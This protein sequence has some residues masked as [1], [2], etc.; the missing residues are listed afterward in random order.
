MNQIP[1]RKEPRRPFTKIAVGVFVIIAVMHLLRLILGWKVT[2]NEAMIPV[3][4]SIP[5]VIVPLVL[6]VMVWREAHS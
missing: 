6:A 5:A 4:V 2:L 3:W 1:D